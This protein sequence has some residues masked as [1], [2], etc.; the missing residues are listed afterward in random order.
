LKRTNL[1]FHKRKKIL[2]SIKQWIRS[3]LEVIIL[4][5]VDWLGLAPLIGARR[6]NIKI[7]DQLGIIQQLRGQNFVIFLPS[8]PSLRGQ[9]FPPERGK[10]QAFF[11]PIPPPPLILST[12]LL[13]D[14]LFRNQ[15]IYF[16]LK[17]TSL[18]RSLPKTCM[19][20]RMVLA[21]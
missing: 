1:S 15:T 11:Y 16:R 8:S 13:N 7:K 12:K 14:P 21:D 3:D 6:G 17:T 2:Y 18:T 10:K 4:N 19:S 20:S 5:L 9:F